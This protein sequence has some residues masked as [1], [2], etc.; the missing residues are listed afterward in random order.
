MLK[1]THDELLDSDNRFV[2]KSKDDSSSY[3]ID[4]SSVMNKNHDTD[5]KER[6]KKNKSENDK[7]N[8]KSDK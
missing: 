5:D 8:K 3:T 2:I 6:N 7:S 4:L 1:V